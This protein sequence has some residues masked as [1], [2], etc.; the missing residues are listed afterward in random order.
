MA[1]AA[2]W[3]FTITGTFASVQLLR[4]APMSALVPIAGTMVLLAAVAANAVAISP[5]Q[6]FALAHWGWAS[7]AWFA[8]LLWWRHPLRWLGAAMLANIAVTFAALVITRDLSRIDVARI[9]MVF[10][11]AGAIQLGVAAG[12]KALENT[13]RRASQI[14]SAE[15]VLA[16]NREAAQRIHTDRRR[17]YR[18][19]GHD[20]RQLLAGLA[21]STLD[22]GAE[23]VQQRCGV[24]AARL[25]R[26]LAEHDDSPSPLLHE[27]RACATN[28]ERNGVAVTLEA[29]GVEPD[30]PVKVRRALCEVPIHLLAATRTQARLTVVCTQEP[31]QV[32]ISVVA[33]AGALPQAM[34]APAEIEMFASREEELLWVRTRWAPRSS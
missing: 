31:I 32:D 20:V 9:I 6:N 23:H 21:A 17:R 27:L 19:I 2:W 4:A 26:L 28:A 3:L 33:D 15:M 24:Q 12:G 22:P 25:R 10:Y 8:M 18:D 13:A 11:G 5:Q 7:F 34:P 30:L 29:V 16:T 1:L 14:S